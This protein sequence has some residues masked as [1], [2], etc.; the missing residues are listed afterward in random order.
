MQ[1]CKILS[2]VFEHGTAYGKKGDEVIVPDHIAAANSKSAKNKKPALEIV[3]PFVKEEDV[4]PVA[5]ASR[6]PNA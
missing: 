6:K 4:V 2:N 5:K 3:E 1:R